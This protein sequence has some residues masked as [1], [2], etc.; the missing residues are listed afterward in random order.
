MPARLL[1]IALGQF[2]NCLEATTWHSR[3]SSIEYRRRSD[4][5]PIGGK[6]EPVRFLGEAPGGA[7]SVLGLLIFDSPSCTIRH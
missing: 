7:R 3:E 1:E 2:G 6:A 5:H 4:G